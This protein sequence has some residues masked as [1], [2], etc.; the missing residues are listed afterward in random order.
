VTS[1][2]HSGARSYNLVAFATNHVSVELAAVALAMAAVALA[3]VALA[4]VALAAATIVA[5]QSDT[6]TVPFVPL[7]AVR[8]TPG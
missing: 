6:V 4:A 8:H 7:G 1:L 2:S 3:A 5:G